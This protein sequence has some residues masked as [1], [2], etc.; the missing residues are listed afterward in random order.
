MQAPWLMNLQ[1]TLHPKICLLFCVAQSSSSCGFGNKELTADL[2]SPGGQRVNSKKIPIEK[3]I[4][5][6]P[7]LGRYEL[8]QHHVLNDGKDFVSQIHLYL[9]IPLHR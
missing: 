1:L 7:C 8:A 9:G 2:Q 6:T 5:E 3:A 4:Q